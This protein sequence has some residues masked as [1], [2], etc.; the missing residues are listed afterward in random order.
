MTP[1]I[2]IERGFKKWGLL[3]VPA[4]CAA[5]AIVTY[6]VTFR[7][8]PATENPQ[9][10]GTFGDFLG[11]L[12]NPLVSTLTLF[13]AISVWQLQRE[14]LKLT[15]DE[16]EQTKRAMTDQAK[17]AELQRQEQRFFDL[18]NV[19]QQTLGS[20]THIEKQQSGHQET[21][22]FGKQAIAAWINESKVD[23]PAPDLL[24]LSDSEFEKLS[25]GVTR[26]SWGDFDDS[27]MF[28]HYIRVIIHILTEAE[29]LLG[30]QHIRYIKLFRAQLS[31]SELI[32]L[33]S[34]LWRQDAQDT[35][36]TPLA[37][38]YGLL[39]HLPQGHLRTTLEQELPAQ[40]FG[41]TRTAELAAA[42]SPADRQPRA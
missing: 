1:K 26:D 20:I 17:T 15:R 18:L 40:V 35:K 36:L 28:D 10:W 16:L 9:A 5:V 30:D 8:L 34:N 13:V 32:L 42:P 39:K 12:L 4:V 25:P 31:R 29:I 22:R 21:H 6:A 11:G 23:Q 3:L 41:R 24:A 2:C 7:D 27:G 14:E 37:E 33:G 19:Y 38:Q